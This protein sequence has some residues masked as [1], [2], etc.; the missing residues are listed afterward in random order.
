LIFEICSRAFK[1][2]FQNVCYQLVILM[3]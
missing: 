3:K 2:Q 1:M